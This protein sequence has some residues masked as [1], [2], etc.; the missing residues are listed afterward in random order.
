MPLA[1][2]TVLLGF[3]LPWTWGISSRVPLPLLAAPV[4]SAVTDF[5][6]EACPRE[7][8][9]C[10]RSGAATENARLQW[11]RRGRD[12]LPQA[13]GQGQ[14]PRGATPLLR[15]GA[16]AERSYSTFKVRRGGREEIP[17]IQGKEQWLHF[18]G[19]AVKRYPTSKVREIPVRQ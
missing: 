8:T 19:A 18:A 15:S 5:T 1:T 6:A 17:L 10:P 3:L 16:V 14:R 9:P 4:Q 12:E 2:P 7:A 11:R 13:Q